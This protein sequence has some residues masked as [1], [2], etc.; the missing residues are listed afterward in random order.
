MVRAIAQMHH[1]LA[2]LRRSGGAIEALAGREGIAP[3]R[4]QSL[5]R[6]THL[7]PVA[8]RAAL[9]GILPPGM[10]LGDLLTAA[11]H[12]DWDRQNQLLRLVGGA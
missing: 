2:A 9:G 10:S 12:L 3:A 4:L 6:L 11:D 1:W 5:L 7:G 8:L